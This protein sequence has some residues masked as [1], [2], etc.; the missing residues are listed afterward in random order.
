MTQTCQSGVALL[1]EYLEGALAPDVREAVE[2]HVAGCQRC[3]AFVESYR[4]TPDVLRN[5]TAVTLPPGLARALQE[6]VRR[7]RGPADE[8]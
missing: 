4:R 5:A 3:I 7:Q 8:R 2:R 6:L 1:M